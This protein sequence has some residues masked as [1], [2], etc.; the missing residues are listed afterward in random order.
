M[1][2]IDRMEKVIGKRLPHDRIGPKD[3]S[4]FSQ[5]ANESAS[6]GMKRRAG[7]GNVAVGG[8]IKAGQDG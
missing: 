4:G 7:I 5:F 1:G 6:M 2:V 3:H 8:L